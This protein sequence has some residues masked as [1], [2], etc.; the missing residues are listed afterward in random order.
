MPRDYRPALIAVSALLLLLIGGGWFVHHKIA[1]RRQKRALEAA[2]GTTQPVAPANASTASGTSGTPGTSGANTA[3]PVAAASGAAPDATANQTPPAPAAIASPEPPPSEPLKLRLETSKT[4][5][6]QVLG[7]GKLLFKGRLHSDDP[8]D[9]QA[10]EGFEVASN[11][12]GAVK[13]QLNGES[14]PF[15]GASSR[16][17]GSVSISR[18]DLKNQAVSAR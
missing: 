8:K 17:G 12:P 13:L 3:T 14:V 7:D 1:V 11:D 6:I 5:R 18:K 4:T 16:H 15:R 9:F 2:S 10:H